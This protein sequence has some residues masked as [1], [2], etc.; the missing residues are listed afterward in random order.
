MIRIYQD[1]EAPHDMHP[2]IESCRHIKDLANHKYDGE[3]LIRSDMVAQLALMWSQSDC[4]RYEGLL[5]NSQEKAAAQ[6]TEVDSNEHAARNTGP[7]D[8]QD[9]RKGPVLDSANPL[10]GFSWAAAHN[11]AL[12]GDFPSVAVSTITSSDA[13][14]EPVFSSRTDDVTSPPP[15]VFG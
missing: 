13:H 8:G 14:S 1:P 12:V 3:Y 10:E 4:S 6:A 9:E 2:G 7:G 15:R 11:L 5:S